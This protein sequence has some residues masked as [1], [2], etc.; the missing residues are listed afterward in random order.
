M[1]F[2][3]G[4]RVLDPTILEFVRVSSLTDSTYILATNTLVQT[5]KNNNIWDKMIILYP[6]VGTTAADRKWNLKDLRDTDS[7]YRLDFVGVWSHQADGSK[8]TSG[9]GNTNLSATTL[10]QFDHHVAFYYTSGSV[11]SGTYDAVGVYQDVYTSRNYSFLRATSTMQYNMTYAAAADPSNTADTID[12]FWCGTRYNSGSLQMI[13][14]EG[15]IRTNTNT[16]SANIPDLELWIGVL[17]NNGVASNPFQNP[18]SFFSVGTGLT[19]IELE[20]LRTA[21][22]DFQTSLGRNV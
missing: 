11:S 15:T 3:F 7:A 6:F 14:P 4:P 19:E 1:S 12:G 5:L 17:N 22:I 18:F 2:T 9:Y 13:T 16:G 8:S 20:I 21:V 10:N